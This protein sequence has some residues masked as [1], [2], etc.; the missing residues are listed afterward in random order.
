MKFL[1][2]YLIPRLAQYVVVMWVGMTIVF[3]IPRLM[4]TDP[5]MSQ[6]STVQATGTYMD[7]AATEQ[8]IGI[9]REMYGLTGGFFEQYGA[10]WQRAFSGDF[11]PSFYMFPTPVIRLIARSL[12]WTLGLLVTGTLVGWVIGS[13]FGGLTGY[14]KDSRIMRFIDSLAMLIRPIPPYILG[15]VLIIVFGYVLGWF[16]LGGAFPIGARISF[17]WR[18]FQ[19]LLRH[20]FLP[21]LSVT[22]LSTAIWHQTMRLIV[23][24]VRDEDYVRYAK[25]GSVREGTIFSRYVMR[26]AILPQITGLT[27]ALGQIFS[28]SLIIEIVFAY[29]GI[30]FLLFQAILNNDYN[31]I[32]GITTISVFAIVTFILLIDLIYP[33]VDPRIRYR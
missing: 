17:S 13:I 28:G 18:V 23:Q 8:M 4:P 29:P 24:G 14:F 7:P 32:M 31:L 5:V 1:R 20:A 3:I 22:L 19:A 11:G 12:P 25:I 16:P 2:R 9:L 21:L 6:I 27:L 30:G 33:L 26:N 10:F 15:L